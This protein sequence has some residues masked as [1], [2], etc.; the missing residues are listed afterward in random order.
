MNMH[1]VAPKQFAKKVTDGC[2]GFYY[3]NRVYISEALTP[4][5][6]ATTLIHEINH[7]INDS[8]LQYTTKSQIFEEEYRALVAEH[9]GSN[10]PI[11]R[12][13]YRDCA[14]KVCDDYSVPLPEEHTPN[15]KPPTGIFHR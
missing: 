10:R 9:L 4:T 1:F 3:K 13:F 11:T 6:V 14:E 8:N 7:Y 15:P 5:E 12:N 2:Y